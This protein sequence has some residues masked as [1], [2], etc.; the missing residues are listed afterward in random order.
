MGWLK[1]LIN[2]KEILMKEKFN[3][4]DK[5]TIKVAGVAGIIAGIILSATILLFPC[6]NTDAPMHVFSE[7][8]GKNMVMC[9]MSIL[10]QIIFSPISSIVYVVGVSGILYIFAKMFG[11]KGNFTTQTYMVS[12]VVAPYFIISMFFFIFADETKKIFIWM[13]YAIVAIYLLYLLTLTLKE[14][15]DY[16]TKKAVLTWLIPFSICAIIFLLLMFAPKPHIIIPPS[17]PSI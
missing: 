1:I 15:H 6:N 4:N 2:P 5:N 3:A 12:L 17:K 9:V 16:T 7:I 14:T 8:C 10:L 13:L 11:G